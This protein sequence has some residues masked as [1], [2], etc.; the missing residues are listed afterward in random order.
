MKARRYPELHRYQKALEVLRARL[1][2]RSSLDVTWDPNLEEAG[3]EL[4]VRLREVDDLDVL[5]RDLEEND[6]ALRQFFDI[7]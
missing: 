6:E 7:L 4:T 2:A 3:V 5:R 1:R